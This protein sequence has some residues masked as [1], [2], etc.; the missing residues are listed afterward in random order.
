MLGR[1]DSRRQ[2]TLRRCVGADRAGDDIFRRLHCGVLTVNMLQIPVPQFP[3]C[4]QKHRIDFGFGGFGFLF[5]LG[6]FS[7]HRCQRSGESATQSGKAATWIAVPVSHCLRARRPCYDMRIIDVALVF[8][9]WA[10]RQA[11]HGLKTRA[12]NGESR[13]EVFITQHSALII[14]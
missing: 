9:P 12:T 10:F 14:R 11:E 8:N 6:R 3:C 1:C 2:Q 5:G 13:L 7:F 4:G